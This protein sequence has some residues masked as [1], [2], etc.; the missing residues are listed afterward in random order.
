MKRIIDWEAIAIV[1]F[2]VFVYLLAALIEPCDSHS[3][4]EEVTDVR[5]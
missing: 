3:C 1:L 5:R 4:D 2:I